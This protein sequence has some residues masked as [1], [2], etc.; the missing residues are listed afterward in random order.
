MVLAHS[1]WTRSFG[2]D[3]AVVGRVVVLN[4]KPYTVVGV[5]PESFRS[6]QIPGSDGVPEF[7]APLGYALSDPFACRSCQHLH[8]VGRLKAG[9]S[10][11]GPGPRAEPSPS[12]PISPTPTQRCY[13]VAAKA[14]PAVPSW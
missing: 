5:L 14:P 4:E 9:V 2:A 11:G 12:E 8:L 13:R 3:P 6:L 1:L 7:F 10:P